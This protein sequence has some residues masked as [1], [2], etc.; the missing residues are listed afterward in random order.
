LALQG[1]EA[2]PTLVATLKDGTVSER[3]LAAQALGYLPADKT[4]QT[5]LWTAAQSDQDPA[6]RLHVV[7]ALG[8]QG[9]TSDFADWNALR[10]RESNSDVKK[11]IG[12]A[13]ER[14]G[15]PVEPSIIQSL[16]NWDADKLDS[17]AVGKPAPDFELQAANGE[18][19]R[20][21]D[22]R[23]KKAVVLVFVYGDT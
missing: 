22:F 13:I 3:I 20:L 16:K 8:M 5:A 14:D 11:H 12:Y 17:A 1:A 10:K 2:V 15:K 19:V 4:A 23:G 6:V 7:D 21:G 18:G 9:A